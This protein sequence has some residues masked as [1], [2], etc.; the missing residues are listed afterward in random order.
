MS[1]L[2]FDP[3]KKPGM[4]MVSKDNSTIGFIFKVQPKSEKWPLLNDRF[5]RVATG[6]YIY[7]GLTKGNSQEPA[8]LNLP[9]YKEVKAE[10]IKLY[11]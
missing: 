11:S 5:E 7:L 8:T 4:T 2:K 9:T 10:V 6:S 3:K 1:E